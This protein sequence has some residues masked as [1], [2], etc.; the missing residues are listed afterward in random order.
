[1]E[2]SKAFSMVQPSHNPSTSAQPGPMPPPP[3]IAATPRL[4][5]RTPLAL[6]DHPN[7]PHQFRAGGHPA[8]L[9]L[10]GTGGSEGDLLPLA[11]RVSP[12]SCRLAPRGTAAL[13]GPP[14]FLRRQA[15]GLFDLRDLHRRTRELAGF[16]EWASGS[17]Q[18]PAEKWVAIGYANGAAMAASLL[19]SG[20]PLAGAVLLRPI[21]P[22]RP[23]T[24]PDLS[25]IPVLMIHAQKDPYSP[26]AQVAELSY[27]LQQMG[28]L[29]QCEE[30]PPGH[31]IG[32]ADTELIEEWL[33]HWF[34]G[35]V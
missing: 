13:G 27:N 20:F 1:M 6:N 8:L 28:A 35:P 11:A 33:L 5:L 32:P 7:R 26:E 17:Y 16:V 14:C 3:G 22:F 23:E 25:R 21:I 18:M 34:P 29:V 12:S 2:T 9:L 4:S 19:L 31:S 10:H 30:V 15:V 24:L